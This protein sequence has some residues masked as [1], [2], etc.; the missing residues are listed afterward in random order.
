V[1]EERI[2][3]KVDQYKADHDR[4]LKSLRQQER[5][6]EWRKQKARERLTAELQYKLDL[7]KYLQD[8]LE[9]AVKHEYNPISP[10]WMYG[11]D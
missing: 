5:A 1:Q 4:E 3:E 7:A 9:P 6:E 2:K 8:A 11:A 10:R